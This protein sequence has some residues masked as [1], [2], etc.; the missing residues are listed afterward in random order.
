M[1]KLAAVVFLAATVIGCE[2]QPSKLDDVGQPMP[3]AL[4]IDSVAAASADHSGSVE[5]RLTRLEI[6]LAKNREALGFL[7]QVYGQQKQQM[8]AEAAKEHAPDAMF[9]VPVAGDIKAGML[10]GPATAQVT[11]V[12]AFDFAFPYCMQVNDMMTELVKEYPG[13]VRVVYKNLVVH[14]D[15]AMPGHLASCAAAKQGKYKEFK[16]AFWDKAFTPYANSRGAEAA[17]MGK[18]NILAFSKELGLDTAKLAADM[19]GEECKQLIAQDMGELEPFQVGSTPA[20]FINGRIV[21]GALPKP[22]FKK[23]IDEELAKAEKS[24]VSGDYY[25]RVVI[26][27]G[28]TK[29]RSKKDPKPQ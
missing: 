8:E 5:D 10:E 26:A 29:F 24:G 18:D 20:F 22:A 27:K 4:Q 17:A 19:D 28:E 9:A 3:K 14:P 1:H 21:V 15:S 12:K 6:E 25:E 7:N 11:I 16:R 2:K 23:L 13:K